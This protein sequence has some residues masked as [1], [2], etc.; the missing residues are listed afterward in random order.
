MHPDESSPKICCAPIAQ[1]SPGV[2]LTPLLMQGVLHVKSYI[3]HR[4]TRAT[5]AAPTLMDAVICAELPFSWPNGSFKFECLSPLAGCVST[6]GCQTQLH[7]EQHSLQSLWAQS[8]SCTCAT[9]TQSGILFAKVMRSPST[10]NCPGR[11]T[12]VS[13]LLPFKTKSAVKAH[14]RS[15]P[16]Q[17]GELFSSYTEPLWCLRSVTAGL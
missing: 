7:W 3:W 15:V 16:P 9:G 10:T 13:L 12:G 11:I 8:S 17:A 4:L 14:L 1:P 6:A 5:A 2:F